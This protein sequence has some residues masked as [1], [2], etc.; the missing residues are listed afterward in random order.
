[1]HEAHE[2]FCT[3]ALRPRKTRQVSYDVDVFSADEPTPPA[4]QE[5]RGWQ[6]VV[7]GP[8]HVETEDIPEQVRTVLPGV[9]FLTQFHLEGNAPATAQKK[10]MTL[11][12]DVARTARGVVIDQQHGTVETPRGVQ[13]LEVEPQW[14]GG[15]LLQVSWFVHDVEPLAR[16]LPTEII[17]AFQR[18]IPELLPRRYGLYEPPQFKLQTQGLD[19]LRQFLKKNLRDSVVWYCHKPCQ[20]LFVSIP[21]RVGPTPR[22]FRCG[23]LTLDMDGNVAGDR[24][25][26]VELTRLWLTVANLIQ[27][28]YAEIRM[29]ACPTKSWWWNGIPSRTPSALLI[30]KP[31]VGLWP[32][33]ES[34]AH[35]WSAE[36]RYMEK[37]ADTASDDTESCLPSP[38]VSI[39]Q[40]PEPMRQTVF[41]PAKPQDMLA[42]FQ[43]HATPYPDVWPFEGPFS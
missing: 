1:M 6:I 34:P 3:R 30:G 14:T 23:R 8:L 32:D 36:L 42:M 2:G 29:G 18:T 16:T 9:R 20:Y 21:D 17:D 41:D 37:F 40:P 10:L 19:H 11:A 38:P 25:W 26:R 13:R 5:G 27:P 31:Y 39:A 15:R 4:P 35:S 43:V 24:A 12:R 7:D 22:G 33:F 28:F